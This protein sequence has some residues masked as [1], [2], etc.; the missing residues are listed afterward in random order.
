MNHTT[1]DSASAPPPESSD[2]RFMNVPANAAVT[3]GTCQLKIGRDG[4][5][6]NATGGPN[7]I[8]S[9]GPVMSSEVK[10]RLMTRPAKIPAVRPDHS[11]GVNGDF[12]VY[13]A[14][15]ALRAALRNLLITAAQTLRAMPGSS[16]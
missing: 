10:N 3:M 13:D 8:T 7:S 4:A 12:M 6:S 9:Q 14:L 2:D 1:I 5:I 15:A 11:R 16:R